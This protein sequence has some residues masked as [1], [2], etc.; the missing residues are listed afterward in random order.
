MGSVPNCRK[1]IADHYPI[2]WFK[3][4]LKPPKKAQKCEQCK[5]GCESENERVQAGHGDRCIGRNFSMLGF[6]DHK[7]IVR[8]PKLS[9]C[10]TVHKACS[11]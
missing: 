6:K 1:E 9:S 2:R 4:K 8:L 11:K 3:C 7:L 5:G 10:G